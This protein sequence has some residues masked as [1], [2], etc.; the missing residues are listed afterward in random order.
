MKCQNVVLSPFV[1]NVCWWFN[2]KDYLHNESVIISSLLILWQVA[3][4]TS[5]H[6]ALHGWPPRTVRSQHTSR[7]LRCL[8]SLP[9]LWNQPLPVASRA[10][11]RLELSRLPAAKGLT[12][13]LWDLALLID[14]AIVM[15]FKSKSAVIGN[16][17]VKD[18]RLCRRC[19][20]WS[21]HV[22]VKGNVALGPLGD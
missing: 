16:I 6:D 13:G 17:N 7:H 14:D 15:K 21:N 22:V 5:K 8:V 4:A 11:A 1:A 9:L 3:Q 20:L 2:C 18:I 10:P 19:A 12:G